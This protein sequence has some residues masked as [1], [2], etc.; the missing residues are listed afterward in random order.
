MSNAVPDQDAYNSFVSRILKSREDAKANKDYILWG[1]LMN[2]AMYGEGSRLRDIY[3][4]EEFAAV[5]PADLTGMVRDLR[6]YKHRIFFYGKDEESAIA[7]LEKHHQVSLPLMDYPEPK[8]YVPVETGGKVYFT[9]F[10]MVQTELLFVGKCDLFDADKMAAASVFNAYFGG[11]MSSVVFQEI[12]ESRS[13]AYAAMA[14]YESAPKTEENDWSLA[15][16]GTQSNKL[17]EAVGAMTE[18]LN[19]MPVVQQKFLQAKESALKQIAAER[20]TRSGIFWTYESLKRRGLEH[21]IR[22]DVYQDIEQMTIG[23]LVAFFNENVR[24]TRYSLVIIGN[25]DDLDLESIQKLGELEEMDVD[26]LFN[27][28]PELVKP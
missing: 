18:L 2:Y 16:L 23:D 7:S 22:E 11:T 5:D 12:R 21:D 13:L 27:F 1:G 8:I 14:I 24:D 9:D 3:S 28:E 15:Y 10:D 17:E 25:K 26:Y 19:E 20:I 4:P 6:K